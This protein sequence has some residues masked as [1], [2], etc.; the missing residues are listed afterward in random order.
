[1]YI[2]FISRIYVCLLII[3]CGSEAEEVLETTKATFEPIRFCLKTDSSGSCSELSLS[4]KAGTTQVYSSTTTKLE[5][6]S[7]SV[8]FTWYYLNLDGCRTKIS[9]NISEFSSSGNHTVTSSLTNLDGL[10]TGLYELELT[11]S[12]NSRSSYFTVL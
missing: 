2:K 11:H 6:D 7:G 10:Q 3:S 9:E 8:V 5:P 1:M 4:V 12:N